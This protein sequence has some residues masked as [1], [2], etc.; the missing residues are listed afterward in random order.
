[1]CLGD[2]M[3]K[4]RLKKS[5]IIAFAAIVLFI[6]MLISIIMFVKHINSSEYKLEKIGYNEKQINEIIKLKKDDFFLNHDYNESYLPLMNEKYY[7][8]KNLNNYLS[9]INDLKKEKKKIDYSDVIARV[10]VK[11]TNGFYKNTKEADVKKGNEI[12]VNKFYYLTKDYSPSDIV[13]M[14][15]WYAFEGR[16]IKKEVYD[17]FIEMYNAA[18]KDNLTLIAN[19]GYRDYNY[20]TRLYDEYKDRDGTEYADTYAA[21]PGYSEHQ[22]GLALDI[23][24][25]GAT[26]ENFDK[27]DT[28]KWLQDNAADY[29]FILRY[30]KDKEYL[31]GYSYESWHYRYLGKELAKKVKDSGLTY[32]EY[33][34]YYLDK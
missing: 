25:Y 8:E 19:S 5:A 30:P 20:Q 12:L 29:G 24:S 33:Y 13:D 17:A 23:V 22:T 11:A 27:T 9:Y 26:M 3:K 15:N 4:R 16:K 28:F 14:S 18:K 1:M 31:T 32:D 21:R 34:A 7:L 6:V 10:N 2:D